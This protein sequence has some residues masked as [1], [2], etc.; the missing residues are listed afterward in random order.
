MRGQSFFGFST[1]Y[2]IFHDDVDP[3]W[4]R[5]RVLE[6]LSS[7]AAELPPG[8]VPTLGPDGTGVGHVFQY[9]IE[10]DGTEPPQSLADLRSLH[11]W[12]VRPKPRWLRESRRWRHPMG[13][14]VREYQV[15]L[16]PMTFAPAT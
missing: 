6:R 2:L 4:A 12:Y 7:A 14:F 1:I 9:T 10:N 3:S 5:S 11:D 8:V 13:G 15:E 16:T